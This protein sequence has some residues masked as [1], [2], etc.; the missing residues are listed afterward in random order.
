[1]A[2]EITGN[3]SHTGT[4]LEEAAK[5]WGNELAF[6]SGE[7]PENEDNQE[8][9]E[10][11]EEPDSEED[12]QEEEEYEEDEEEPEEQLFEVKSNGEV[13]SV[14]LQQLQDNFSKGENYTQKS[15]SLADERK[16]FEQE[17]ADSRQLRDQAINV[18]ETAKAQTQP[19]QQDPAYWQ[20]LKD[21]DPMEF[22]LQRDSLREAQMQNQL[23]DQQLNQLRLQEDADERKKLEDYVGL[24][25][26]ELKSLVPEWSN[27][28][29]ANAEKQLVLE[30]GKRV[31]FSAEEMEN[32]YDARAV[33]TMR[34]AALYDQLTEKRKGLK[35]VQRKSMKAG[36]K[37]GDPSS[38][39]V[40][41]AATRLKQSG[42]L[43]D[44]AGVFYNMI[45]SK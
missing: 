41:K 18:L 29:T 32:A 43:E 9:A 25:R 40:V 13:K 8:R 38:A 7:E 27:E 2:E 35:P 30:Y 14:T 12:V 11:E 19:E 42:N 6:E 45:R 3:T 15:Q 1:M 20:D 16:S 31:G 22:M 28:E 4:D 24:Q 44:A 37:S 5:M 36:S 10:S 34:K 23:R 21:N 17:M 26:D 33:A 39:R